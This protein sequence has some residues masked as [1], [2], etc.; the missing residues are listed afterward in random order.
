MMDSPNANSSQNV[1]SSSNL[2]KYP[3][4]TCDNTVTW[5]Q[6]GVACETCGQWFHA[7]CQSLG[8]EY[9]NLNESDIS[10]H[11]VICGNPNYSN[12]TYDLYGLST[13][14]AQNP[15]QSL[16]SASLSFTSVASL[17]P[18]FNP[19]HS[20]SPSKDRPKAHPNSKFPRPL[21]IININ[22]CSVKGKKADISNLISSLQPDIIVGTETKI[23]SHIAD[24]EF[25][26][27][28]FKSHRRDRNV[29]GGG[30]LIALKEELFVNSTRLEEFETDCEILWIK[31]STKDNKN[32]HICSYYRPHVSDE[33]SLKNFALSLQKVCSND[34]RKVLVAGDLNFPDWDWTTN[35]LKPQPSYPRLH[36]DFFD[37]LQDHS[38]EQLVTEPT[39]G[40]NTLDLV[41]TNT[42]YLVPRIHTIP[43]LSDH[44]AVFFEFKCRVMRNIKKPH[45][46]FLYNRANFDEIRNDLK[47]TS[48]KIESMNS[49]NKSADELWNLFESSL[50]NT[51][52]KNVPSKMTSNKTS[53]PWITYA[54]KKLIRKRD[55][56][57]KKMKKSKSPKLIKEVKDLKRQV[58]QCLRRAHWDH[59]NSLFAKHQ[60]DLDIHQKNK[61]FWSYIKQQKASNVGVPPLKDNGQLITNARDKAQVLNNQFNS[62][63]SEGRHYSDI[64]INTKC[65]LPEKK[66]PPIPDIK[67]DQAGIKKLLDSLDTSKAPGPDGV[68]PKILQALA[69]EIAPMLTTIFSCSLSTGVVPLAWKS[70]NVSP[71]YKKGEHYKASNYRPISLTCICCKILEHVLVSNIM[72]HWEKHNVLVPNQHGFRSKRSCESQ[73][74]EL[75][76]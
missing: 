67:V 28:N 48:S 14:S 56:A 19:I 74:I 55:R 25:L 27:P 72:A 13:E 41:I 3:C 70:A 51:I 52:N 47:E 29:H 24:S 12:Y 11:C 9:S 30:V 5:D 76:D 8:S 53:L 23:D 32:L 68:S 39:R 57:Y 45:K 66:A 21:R 69:P 59:V 36:K 33:D 37:L 65:K 71:V 31:L 7:S 75:M 18:N 54:I 38:L 4:G 2:S 10:W 63:F 44:D 40:D 43:G 62:A 58:Q 64:D 73:L 46:V 17:S 22:F 20:S 34:K 42:P 6:R 49:D 61:R 50:H 60:D 26:P 1:S 35:A 16:Q 15:L